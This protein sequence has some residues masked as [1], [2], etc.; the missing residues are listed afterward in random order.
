MKRH[1][2]YTIL[3]AGSV[4]A[5][6]TSCSD[7]LEEQDKVEI[8]KKDYLKDA[9]EAQNVLLG[10]YRTNVQ[11]S[12]YG[13]H[14]SILLNVGTDMEQIEGSNTENWRIIPTNAYPAT[15]A[16]I[17]Q[18]WQGLYQG[19]Y[20]ANDF[21]ENLSAHVDSYTDTD[22]KLALVYAAEARTLR[23]LYYFELVRRWNK[24]P[25]FTKTEQSDQQPATFVQADPAEV[26]KFIESD[27]KY[28]IDILPY[29]TDDNLRSDNSYRL[30][31]GAAIGLLAKVYATWAGYPVHDTTKWKDAAETAAQ[32]INSGKHDLLTDFEQ[33]W[34][35]T[36]NGV[37]DPTESLIEISF[38]SPTAAGG[39][40]DPC[41]YIGKWNGVVT[42][43]ISGTRGSCKG[44]V[45][46][47]YPFS[48]QWQ[49]L[50]DKRWALSVANFQ[51]KP[52]KTF[53]G[54]AGNYT[55]NDTQVALTAEE[56]SLTPGVDQKNKQYF[57]P[58]KWD[59][60][61]YT[62]SANK[63]INDDRSNTN[64]YVL[65]YADVL[66]IYAEALNEWKGYPTTEAY[67]AINKVRRRGWGYPSNTATCDLPAGMSQ[68]EF[69]K[70]IRN[71]RGYELAFEGHRRLDLVR[72]GIYAQTIKETYNT[73]RDWWTND[74]DNFNYIIYQY[75]LEG[76]HELCPIPQHDM[77]LC[78][79]FKQNPNW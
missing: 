61:K 13:R 6:F 55:I 2:L 17:Q 11:E 50:G 78:P 42:S 72:W 59:I 20:R 3:F 66:L 22:K 23:A 49:K 32:L 70:A 7:F 74:S 8:E 26:Y 76:K 24:V 45:K 46:V 5:A 68:D 52:T 65:R 39:A 4:G 56:A 31:K 1:L 71:E 34:K 33:L 48:Y 69:R 67:A 21:L 44:N 18:A 25:L 14:L 19:I 60:E 40:S 37:W 41:G 9:D 16:E 58:A 35:N 77:D 10:V 12:L 27:L 30:S 51:Y 54:K 36:A 15:Q 63:L 79:Q 53:Y 28:A 38:Y 75:T 62:D 73:L 29:A 47:V 43:Q 64:W 57:T